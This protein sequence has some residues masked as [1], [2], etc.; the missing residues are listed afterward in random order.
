MSD[1]VTAD[2]QK[3]T[4]AVASATET[5]KNTEK[6]ICG[7]VM[8]ISAIDGYPET[9]WSDV[10][11]ILTEAIEVSGFQAQLVSTAEDVGT[12]HRRIVQNLHENP[13]IVCDVSG[14]NPN[15]MFELGMRLTFDKPVVIVK[16]DVTSYSFDTSPIEHVPYRRD[17]RYAQTIEF[18]RELARK[19]SATHAKFIEDPTSTTFLKHFGSFTTGTLD[20]KEVSSQEYILEQVKEL[21]LSSVQTSERNQQAALAKVM[22]DLANLINTRVGPSYPPIGGTSGGGLADYSSL[23]LGSRTPGLAGYESPVLDALKKIEPR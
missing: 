1:K 15:V 10:R 12:I 19:I 20:K 23:R 16:D 9:H 8:P 13:I 7:L 22:S 21:L 17:L 14:K 5:T 11:A 6:P 18:K 3:S 2:K 4:K